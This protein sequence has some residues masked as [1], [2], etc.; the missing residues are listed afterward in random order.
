MKLFIGI[1]SGDFG[2]YNDFNTCL[3]KL[4]KP[5]DIII[6]RA[7]GAS[8]AR[9]RN[10]IIRLAMQNQCDYLLFLDD[11]MVFN[12]DLFY[13]LFSHNKEVVT[14]H[15]LIR[16]PPFKSALVDGINL[17]ND[18]ILHDLKPE[19]KGLIK[20]WAAGLACTLINCRVLEKF[21]QYTSIGWLHHDELSEDISFYMQ[22]HEAGFDSYCDLDCHVGHH[23]NSVI[24]PDG[25]IIVNNYICGEIQNAILL[26]RN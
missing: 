26:Q 13:Q 10:S 8:V 25:K 20:I 6:H 17:N 3:D 2:R 7:I 1:P 16:Y 5:N 18:L 9:N 23:I 19:E 11:D 15:C 14:A 22:L 12:P 4:G 24:W 21:E